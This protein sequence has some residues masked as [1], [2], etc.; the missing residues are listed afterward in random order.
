MPILIPKIQ[1]GQNDINL[2]SYGMT[3]LYNNGTTVVQSDPFY[4]EY[5]CRN[6]Y[7]DIL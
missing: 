2:T 4:I 3:F 1:L 5:E 6:K 7:N